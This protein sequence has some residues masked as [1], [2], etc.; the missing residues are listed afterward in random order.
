MN[1]LDKL[2]S[3]AAARIT[4]LQ[5][6]IETLEQFVKSAE[7]AAAILLPDSSTGVRILPRPA[8]PLSPSTHK[9]VRALT[10]VRVSAN[11][12]VEKIISASIDILH[13]RGQPLTRRALYEALRDRG[14]V[15][16]G[17]D[18]VK[19]LG[20]MLW[21]SSTRITSHEGRGYWP[22]GEPLPPPPDPASLDLEHFI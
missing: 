4:V 21:R 8:A 2:K 17:A 11:P 14:L 15:I 9:A 16:V 5:Q 13:E 1:A 7:A 10:K 18:P 3:Q 20:T 12:P 22:A 6:E 19:A